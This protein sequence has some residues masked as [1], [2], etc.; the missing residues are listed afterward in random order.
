MRGNLKDMLRDA[1][2]TKKLNNYITGHAQVDVGGDRYGA[3]YSVQ[4]VYDFK[5]QLDQ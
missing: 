3:G 1:G 4:I 2:V 5:T